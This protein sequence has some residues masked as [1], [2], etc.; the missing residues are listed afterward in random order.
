MNNLTGMTRLDLQLEDGEIDDYLK[1][2]ANYVRVDD[3]YGD[4][5]YDF[6]F[7]IQNLFNTPFE[8]ISS[9]TQ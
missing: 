5:H 8:Y 2:Y 1:V 4:Y 9:V 3:G 7:N 6:Y